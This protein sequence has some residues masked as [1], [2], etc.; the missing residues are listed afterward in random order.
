MNANQIISILI[1]I[2]R[3]R[4]ELE[5]G[6]ASMKVT[7]EDSG[8]AAL[9]QWCRQIERETNAHIID[10]QRVSAARAGVEQRT[11]E[12]ARILGTLL[13]RTVPIKDLL[14]KGNSL[15][16]SKYPYSID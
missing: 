7:T 13:R 9:A 4:D 10:L 16:N 5:G 15:K 8:E 1:S 2:F 14:R 11:R 12:V 3:A 6:F